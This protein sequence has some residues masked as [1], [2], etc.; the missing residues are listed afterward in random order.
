ME[1]RE[2]NLQVVAEG[3]RAQLAQEVL[4]SAFS[5]LW[6][7]TYGQIKVQFTQGATPETIYF[8]VSQLVALDNCQDKILAKIKSAARLESENLKK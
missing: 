1:K 7:A 3:G 6:L 4:G 2:K 8:L 5:D